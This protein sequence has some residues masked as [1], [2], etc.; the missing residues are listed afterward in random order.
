MMARLRELFAQHRWWFSGLAV[1]VVVGGSLGAAR[2]ARTAPNIATAEVIKGEFVDRVELRGEVRAMRS[3]T[4]SAPFGAGDIQILNLARNGSQVKTGENVIEF[5]SYTLQRQLE[6]RQTELRQAEAEINRTRAQAKMT[7]E[8]NTTSLLQA[9]YNVERARLEVSKSE[10]LSVIDG[11]ENKLA[12]N[13]MEKKLQE[14]QQKLDS[15]KI[16]AQADISNRIFRRD[17]TAA[18]VARIQGRIEALTIHAPVDGLFNVMPNI[19][20]GG[21]F[22]FST[23]SS[24]SSMPEYRP[25][26][27]A[28][29]GAA[30]AEIPDL[31]T[32]RV[33]ARVEEI[34]RGRVATGQ[35]VTVRVD[36]LPDKE[37][38]ARVTDIS[39]MAKLDFS[40]FPPAKNFDVVMTVD[41][42]DP[43]LR[44]GMTATSRI[45]VDRIPNAIIIPAEAAFQKSGRTLVYVLRGTKFEE[46][47]IEVLRRG[48]GR[49][50]VAKGLAPGERV[51]LVDPTL[52]QEQKQK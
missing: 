37:L 23:S 16:G 33:T 39:L 14:V 15:D 50:A 31:S 12:L 45:A 20:G 42:L 43:R 7:E 18:E 41:K 52:Q 35:D 38:T 11:E 46:R 5:D 51:A 17:R 25:G 10:I 40:T 27:R 2:L 8:A 6:Q 44:P 49:V 48:T 3:V 32:L 47:Q 30:I 19:R 26:D 36:A 24:S 9:R 4:L 34:D 28:W 22:R 13:N 1:L 29:S 21:M